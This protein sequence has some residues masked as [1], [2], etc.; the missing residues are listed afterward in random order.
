MEK[1]TNKYLETLGYIIMIIVVMVAGLLM[2]I[3]SAGNSLVVYVK[4]KKLLRGFAT[5]IFY[6]SMFLGI[7]ILGQYV[8]DDGRPRKK[9]TFTMVTDLVKC[10][11]NINDF[12]ALER[13]KKLW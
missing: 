13:S 5:F 7:F 6:T 2:A 10:V 8:S 4:S 9:F 11:T 1:N 3:Y 12:D